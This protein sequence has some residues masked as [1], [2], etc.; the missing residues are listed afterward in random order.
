MYANTNQANTHEANSTDSQPS[1][2]LYMKMKTC[3]LGFIVALFTVSP[4]FA[5]ADYDDWWLCANECAPDDA[6]CVDK[7]TDE[8]N[9]THSTP[10]PADLCIQ[11]LTDTGFLTAKTGL[12]RASHLKGLKLKR[13]AEGGSLC[14]SKPGIVTPCPTGSVATPFEMPVYDKAGLFVVCYKTVSFCIPEDLEPA[15]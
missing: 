6:A 5:A 11:I 8:Y 7:C 4:V 15:E 14:D 9:E 10:Y 2:G 3:M 12:E 13:D 1:G